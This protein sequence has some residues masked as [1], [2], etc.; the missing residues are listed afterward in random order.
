[1]TLRDARIL[2]VDDEPNVLITVKAILEEDGYAVD[3]AADGEAAL[4]A[5]HACKYDLV[6]TDLKLPGVDGLGV[7]AEV[8]K[9][10]PATVTIMMTGY[11][12][13]DSATEAVHLGAY[14]YLLKPMDVPELKQAVRRSL[15]RKRLSEI[16]T[17]YRV[18][19]AVTGSH[20]RDMVARE[21]EEAARQVLGIAS[22]KIISY[23]ANGIVEPF[24]ET[25]Y[26]F[27]TTEVRHFLEAGAIL[28]PERQPESLNQWAATQNI[29]SYAVV[30]GINQNKLVCVLVVHNN[31]EPYEFHASAIRFLQSLAGQCALVLANAS[32]FSQLQKK[33]NELEVANIKLRE[34]DRLKSQFLSIATHELRTPLT[35]IMGYNAMLAEGMRDR[36]TSQ[37]K[38]LLQESVSACQRLIRLVNSML[39]INQIESGKMTMRF[40]ESDLN[41][42]VRN[43][44]K[45]FEPDA[46][47][48][49][50]HLSLEVPAHL[51][52]LL[53]DA[54]RLEQVVINLVGNAM[55]F[56]HEGG[57]IHLSVRYSEQ[58]QTVQVSVQ[59]T[60][61]G[62]AL[63]DQA[64]I[65][66]EFAQVG[67]HAADRHREGSGLGLAIAKRIV[68]AHSGHITVHSAPGEGSTFTFT[69]PV[70]LSK[71]SSSSAVPA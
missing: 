18:T 2:V 16:D 9:S 26:V 34:L 70:R 31:G 59:D 14:E 19:R 35:I 49:D 43:V 8:R 64:V 63:S 27:G 15:E 62:I 42:V 44:V 51:P 32:L 39:D 5:I 47:R 22:A 24:V 23:R 68:E 65:F 3:T 13:V 55:K 21:I 33:N 20:D 69:L 12:S 38:E 45:L 71:A 11:G 60:G 66:D 17:L 57:G 56:T 29:A 40:A 54:E 30:P 4:E 41:S 6:L 1:M 61:V 25:T 36:A 7:L 58:A 48:K 28:G 52:K 67:K 10:S 37:E 50:I 53:L 46:A